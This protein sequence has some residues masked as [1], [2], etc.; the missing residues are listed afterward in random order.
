MGKIYQVG[1]GKQMNLMTLMYHWG[2]WEG[3]IRV[4]QWHC[5]GTMSLVYIPKALDICDTH[6]R[7]K[8]N[9]E[10]DGFSREFNDAIEWKL[11]LKSF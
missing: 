10:A 4:M 3:H 2:G 5:K 7:N 1:D 9:I 6:L 11:Q 8:K